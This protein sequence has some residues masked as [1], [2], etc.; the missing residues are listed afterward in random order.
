MHGVLAHPLA[1]GPAI[2]ARLPRQAVRGRLLP[3]SALEGRTGPGAVGLG[4]ARIA[5]CLLAC[6]AC[7]KLCVG[8]SLPL[9]QGDSKRG[10]G[11]SG[12]LPKLRMST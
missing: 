7:G 1:A 5:A 2:L 6:L 11:W 10:L 9:V 3:V 4:G 12:V 8:G